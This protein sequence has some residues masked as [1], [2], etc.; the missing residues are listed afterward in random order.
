MIKLI[1]QRF[2]QDRVV[3]SSAKIALYGPNGPVPFAEVDSCK[4]TRKS[5]QKAFQ[6]L[7]EVGE[8]TQDIYEGYELDFSGAVIDPSYDD[9]IDQIDQAAQNGKPNVRFRVTQSITYYDG[10]VKTYVYPDTVLYG[11]DKDIASAKDEIK[12]TC[13][14]SAQKRQAG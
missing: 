7:G 1:L 5:S 13:K 3:G 8:R 11:F 9:I 10:S 14:G 4:E 6:P 12:W 2:A